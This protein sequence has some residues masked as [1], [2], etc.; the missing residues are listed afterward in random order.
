MTEKEREFMIQVALGVFSVD[1][2]GNVWRHGRMMGGSHKGRPS[3][4]KMFNRPQNAA[5]SMKSGYPMVM[6][7]LGHRKRFGILAHRAVWMIANHSDIPDGMEIN[8]KDEN[9]ANHHPAN[10]EMVTRSQNTLHTLKNRQGKRDRQSAKLTDGDV[11]EIRKLWDQ[12]QMTQ[13]AIAEH[14]R[15]SQSVVSHIV[16]RHTWKHLP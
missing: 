13:A 3:Y 4:I 15:T 16:R 1:V 11:I 12:G 6:F 5:T 7:S 8:H 2:N 10:L 9:R 14:Y